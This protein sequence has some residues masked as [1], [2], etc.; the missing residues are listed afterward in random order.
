M[1]ERQRATEDRR[2][3]SLHLTPKARASIAAV[4]RHGG[5]TV[6]A[7]ATAV[8]ISARDLER[9]AVTLA[10]LESALLEVPN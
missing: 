3:V 5:D 2:R 6:T 7:A 4:R 1:V 8:G 10:A 9:A